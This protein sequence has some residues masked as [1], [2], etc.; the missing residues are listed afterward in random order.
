MIKPIQHFNKFLM[1]IIRRKQKQS[2]KN[3]GCWWW[4][5]SNGQTGHAPGQAVKQ[6]FN[7]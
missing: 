2:T 5:I 3:I 4:T 6:I 1:L 7:I